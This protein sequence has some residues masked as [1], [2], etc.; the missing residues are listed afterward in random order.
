MS[1][2]LA[3]LLSTSLQDDLPRAPE[4]F[5]VERLLDVPPELGSW[6]AMTFDG[7]GRLVVSPQEGPLRRLD[8]GRNPPAID[9]VDAP[10]GDAQG[11]LWAHDSLYVNGKGPA[12]C[13]LYRIRDQETRLLRAWPIEMTEHGPHGLALGPDG[14]LYV[15]NG[16]YTRPQGELSPRSP[17]RDGREDLL[18]PRQ[19]DAT[20][21][22]VGL[23]A[24]GGVVLRA[25]PDGK[26]WELYCG[27]LRNAYDLA[28]NPDGE[29]FTYDSDMERD[30]GTPWYR[31]TR[32]FHL[33]P[34]GDY[35]WR[36]G[37]GKWPS[38]WPDAVPPVVDVGRGSP[39]GVAFGTKSRFPERYR[40]AFFAADWA[41]GR[42]LAVHL[43]PKGASYAGTV[44]PFLTG[45]PLNVTDLEFGPDGALY[46]ITGGR[47][48][49]S[50]LYRVSYDGAAGAE[51]GPTASAARELRK[52]LEADQD[53]WPSLGADDRSI[54]TAARLAL[55][56]RPVDAWRR[57]ALTEK[58]SRPALTALLALAHRGSKDDLEPFLD[59]LA[60]LDWALLAESERVELLRLYQLAF[61]RF[62][63]PDSALRDKA[64]ACLNA[65]YPS[66]ADLVDRD[67]AQVL[68]YLKAPRFVRRTLD[69]VGKARS[70]EEATHYVF[71]LRTVRE[72]WTA[73]ERR[74][75]FSWFGKFSDYKGDIGFP[76][77]LRNIRSDALATMTE[78]ERR[79][80]EPLLEAQF[81][82]TMRIVPPSPDQPV[83]V[84]TVQ[85]LAP[86][87]EKGLGK[88]N[89]VRGKASFVKAQCLACHR[90]GGEG[91]A[92]G[93]DLSGLAKRFSRRD[94]L[95]AIL[96]P[97]KNV[98]DQYQNTMIQTTAGDVH[99][100]RLIGEDTDTITLRPDPLGDATIV[101][102]RRSIAARKPSALSPMPEGLLNTLGKFEVLDLLA[103]LEA[104]GRLDDA[105]R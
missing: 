66:A 38:V 76:L 27:G 71:V 87:I 58:Q 91:G 43:E 7:R 22:A 99:V 16:N 64:L 93:P 94:L 88:R 67:L 68:A 13:G 45:Q 30:L 47:G 24:P 39:T 5:K 11:L 104:D 83:H 61:L 37:T 50:T 72:G 18:L 28:F 35:G 33:V 95:E 44:E 49:R 57:R 4:R 98:S 78:A 10:V 6:V 73:D 14:K 2:F 20:G 92:V 8:L 15:I 60:R 41:F 19:W 9:P 74:E 59:A 53:P 100:G 34:G 85:E 89:L 31:P 25:D 3:I 101:L 82:A 70:Q 48:T 79:P 1:L 84:W 42:I 21:H 46:F 36:S 77:F 40:R 29:L 17:Y 97:S 32:I 56:R 63:A 75:Y 96:L 23:L 102:A 103:F 52:R 86:E 54:R 55:E 62:G 65:R 81:R 51:P 105:S 69:L 80:L 90:L 12:G 26:E